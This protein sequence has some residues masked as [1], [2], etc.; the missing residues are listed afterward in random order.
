MIADAVHNDIVSLLR[1]LSTADIFARPSSAVF[2][3]A[4]RLE[5]GF[6][7]SEGYRAL[8]AMENSGFKIGHIADLA[9]VQWF[10][11]F[12]RIYVEDRKF[13]V[14]FLSSADIMAAKLEP[15]NHISKVLTPRLERL[16]VENGTILVSCSGTIGN[17]AICTHDFDDLAVSQHAIR[18]D[19][20]NDVDRGLLYF[21]LLSNL[22]QFLIK[23]NKS[24]SVIESIYAADVEGLS[25]PVLP[26]K[27][28]QKLSEHVALASDCRVKANGLL[29]D[30]E[31]AIQ[32][33]SVEFASKD[34]GSKVFIQPAQM[35]QRAREGEGYSR[36]DATYYDPQVLA[37]RG[38]TLKA[39]GKALVKSV[40]NINLIGKT[41]VDG[42]HKVESDYGVPYFT[43]KELFKTRPI[44]E[45]FI[46]SQRRE[47]IDKL[48]VKRGMTLVTCAGTVGKVMYVRGA[49]EGCAV[50][51]DAIRILPGAAIH[52]GYVYAYLAS[53]SGQAELKRC[54]YGS[55]IPR[56]YRTHV[57]NVVI[58]NVKDGGAEIGRLVDRAF[59]LR[60]KA[61][62][63]ENT[64]VEL[65]LSCLSKGRLATEEEWGTEY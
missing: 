22:G 2:S 54:S 4:H 57:E 15:K 36:L 7:G 25:I 41:F 12:P 34:V 26:K 59:D 51:H 16:L 19:P 14:P 39:G 31:A 61:L 64:S 40:P 65:L 47:S 21:F 62:K 17:V 11:P 46:T 37:L 63:I 10:G 30:A 38:N 8:S 29:A 52:P 5:A 32:A 49:L 58:P 9:N 23:R 48:L 20:R 45:T 1:S 28:R 60:H 44:P 24:G 33:S 6:Y 42:V 43:G 27:L 3:G 13:G 50:T 18:I 55:V 35:V 53:P 56:L